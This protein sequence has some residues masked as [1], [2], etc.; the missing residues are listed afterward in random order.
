MNHI[1]L[2]L[3]EI[4]L[5][6]ET[7]QRELAETLGFSLGKV[8]SLISQAESEGYLESE[9]GQ[10][11]ITSSGSDFLKSFMVDNAIILTAG[12]GSR[13]VPLTYETPKGLLKVFGQPMIERL[14]EQLK[15]K[16]IDEIILVVGY[17]KETFDYLIDKY[18]VTIV[19]NPEFSAK[20]NLASLYVARQ[21]LKNSYLLVADNYIE[22]NIFN[23]YESESWFSSLYFPEKSAEWYVNKQ[24]KAGRI[25]E[26]TIGGADGYV[27][28]GP[29]YFNKTFSTQFS[30]Y[31]EEY[32]ARPETDNFYWEHILRDHLDTLPMY[33]NDQT[34]NVHEFENL[35]ELREYDKSYLDDTKS[36]LMEHIARV[37]KVDQSAISDIEPL[38]DGVTNQ[39]FIFSVSNDSYGKVDK[40]VFRL[41]GTGTDK[42]I[43]RSNEKL[44]YEHIAPLNI[45][46]EIVDFDSESGIKISRYYENS[47]IATPLSDSD[48]DVA[49][50]MIKKVHD[51]AFHIDHSFDIASMIDYYQSLAESINAIRFTDIADVKQDVRHLMDFKDKIAIPEILCHGDYAHTNILFLEDGSAKVIDW[52]YA[53][54]SDPIMD[55]SMYG[56]YALFD[57]ERIDLCL[58]LYLKREPSKSEWAR[59]YLYVALG[60]YLWCMWAE[61]KQGLGQEF[62]EYP[63]QMYRYM[64]D[65]YKLLVEGGYL[66]I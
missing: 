63:L 20:N 47:R 52:E 57:K 60:G 61:Y 48:L 12:F 62:G 8:N 38:K 49:M 11:A 31:L 25:E 64:K 18:D 5:G 7:T 9:A 29:A 51:Q 46:D 40:Y 27:I 37:F 54:A 33:I 65:F 59:L 44:V 16:G 41:P 10:Y 39:S 58:R 45:A 56:I 21:H 26:I 2:L 66:E 55:V 1:V 24:S 28:V 50:T 15:E 42:L 30:K 22:N 53:G 4:I 14:I 17:M 32:Y 19:F 34:G 3:R 35:A 43:D 36:K 6:T 23:T 13:F